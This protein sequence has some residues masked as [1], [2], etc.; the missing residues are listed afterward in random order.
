MRVLKIILTL[1]VFGIALPVFAVAEDRPKVSN[2]GRVEWRFCPTPA[3]QSCPKACAVWANSQTDFG[4]PTT[5]VLRSV[6]NSFSAA[7]SRRNDASCAVGMHRRSPKF[8]KRKGLQLALEPL[9]G[10]G[11]AGY[12]PKP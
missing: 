4:I 9:N 1:T 5:L 7:V 8:Q 2:S 12:V 6:G 10:R 11:I 3:T